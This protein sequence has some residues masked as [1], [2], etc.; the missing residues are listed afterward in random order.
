M[1][2]SFLRRLICCRAALVLASVLVCGVPGCNRPAPAPEKRSPVPS[3]EPSASPSGAL[4]GGDSSHDISGTAPGGSNAKTYRQHGRWLSASFGGGG[5]VQNVVPHP[6]RPGCLFAY[7]DVGGLYRSDDDGKT[8]RMLH[9]GL[10][11]E[12][13]FYSVRG[14]W[15]SPSDPD[16]LLIAV[17]HQWA[18]NHGVFLSRDG[19]STWEK[20]LDVPFLGNEQH[21][22]CGT[23]FLTLGN[24][25]VVVGSAGG[26]LFS[27]SDGGETW[28][29]EG[30]EG[31]NI[32]DVDAGPNGEMYVCAQP[33]TLPGGRGIRGGFFRRA[34][35]ADWER[36]EESPDELAVAFDGALVGLFGSAEVRV[37]RDE[38]RSWEDYSNG[39]PVNREKAQDFVS[40][41]RFRALAAGPD[42]LLVGS[43][44]GTIHRRG[45][46][47]EKWELVTRERVEEPFEGAPWWGRMQEGKWQHFGAAMGSL[48]VDP[49]DPERWWF[50]DWYGIYE[51]RDAGRNWTLR[52]DG[53]EVTVIH[54]LAQDP[55]DPGRVHAGMADNGYIA[56]RDGGRSFS[57][58]KFA[59]NMKALALDH[60][61]AGRI[62][63]AGSR[64]GEWK[65]DTLWVSVDGGTTWSP[66]PMRGLPPAGRRWINSLAVRPGHPYEIA[67]ALGGSGGGVWRSLDGGRT[68]H[69]LNEGM[70]GAGDFFQ[71]EIWAQVAELAW[72]QNGTMVAISHRTGKMFVRPADGPWRETAASL[73]G[74]PYQVRHQ[75][76]LFYMTRGPSGLWRSADGS[77]WDNLL[78][79]PAEILAV[80]A[81]EAGRLA[82]AAK[83]QILLTKD[84]GANWE[85]IPAPPHGL[86][87]TM[88]FAG[89]RLLVGTRGGGF[90]LTAL[91]DEDASVAAGPAAPGTLPVVEESSIR[92]PVLAGHWTKPWKKS[93]EL[94]VE[95]REAP[96]GIRLASI[97]GKASGSTGLLFEATGEAFRLTGTWAVD[98]GT[99]RLAAR[100]L[101]ENGAQI[102]WQ[103]LGERR[104]DGGE[105]SFDFQIELPAGAARGELVLLFEGE[106]SVAVGNL[107][108]TRPDPHFG[109]PLPSTP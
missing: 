34:A 96:S 7:V 100:A 101:G 67:L 108:V 90:F 23:V 15:V 39:L 41:S 29:S 50:T 42:F 78:K 68:F 30:L 45:S 22:S 92:L 13:G 31:V 17:G 38:G 3:A 80:D 75:G 58:E 47:D 87:S 32:T 79:E 48:V 28:T 56:S 97:G 43:G 24:G 89:E 83:G 8:W 4:D 76:G 85:K 20:R 61:L 5:Y 107:A 64:G 73:P 82:V 2:L 21:R 88:A 11:P 27:S 51:T 54:T 14:L 49:A 59:S 77:A 105:T 6:T 91:G 102:H 93:G 106:G 94:R 72:A 18:A 84:A 35:G 63:G 26:G 69:A 109:T 81:A 1:R 9:G 70:E 16:R 40:E 98:G 99:A 104:A 74:Q 65:A 52:I 33:H 53:I 37:S 44:R 57:G 25:T 55:G 19:G 66:A 71:K 12:E 10:P 60:T 36:I 95:E 103:P 86:I 46:G 62:Y